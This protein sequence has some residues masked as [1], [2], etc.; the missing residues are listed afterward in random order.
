MKKKICYLNIVATLLLM[1]YSVRSVA[2][3]D[4][5]K[6]S[7]TNDAVVK[8]VKP[9]DSMAVIPPHTNDNM[10]V[11][12]DTGFISKNIIDNMMEIQAAEVGRSKGNVQVKKVADLIIKDHTAMLNAL[13]GLARKKHP[14][15][16]NPN[17]STHSAPPVTVPKGSDFNSTWASGMLTMHEEKI[18]E[19]NAFI[20]FTQDAELKA[21]ATQALATITVHRDLL[22]KIPGAKVISEKNVA[23]L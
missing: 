22:A 4:T 10:A 19:L 16:A 3:T 23:R 8:P 1:I 9:N 2:Q 12:T 5:A 6:T 15:A 13:Q 14:R 7:K 18:K 17:K 11:L 21:F 20:S